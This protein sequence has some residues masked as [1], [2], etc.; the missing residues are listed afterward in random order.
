[1][2]AR[3]LLGCALGPAL[4]FASAC[5]STATNA[6]APAPS[7][8]SVSTGPSGESVP[9]GRGKSIG[10]FRTREHELTLFASASGTKVTVRTHEGV[11]LAERVD[12]DMLRHEHPELWQIVKGA[13]AAE[14][15]Y[16]DATLDHRPS[17]TS[18]RGSPRVFERDDL[19][20]R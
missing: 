2:N 13:L 8:P 7:E 11:L 18:F 17:P 15:A 3:T 9:G 14:G 4:F 20:R 6:P 12:A 10:R 5:G 19:P 16:L 1:M